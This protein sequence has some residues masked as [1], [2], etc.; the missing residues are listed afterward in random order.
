[1]TCACSLNDPLS[2]AALEELER[3]RV[4]E[5]VSGLGNPPRGFYQT[6]GGFPCD[7]SSPAYV[8][9]ILMPTPNYDA[10]S[11]DQKFA[12]QNIDVYPRWRLYGGPFL[13]KQDAD[14]WDQYLFFYAFNTGQTWISHGTVCIVPS[15]V[16]AW[17]PNAET[18]W[19]WVSETKKPDLAQKVWNKNTGRYEINWV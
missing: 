2:K 5:W 13:V 11:F 4:L 6:D 18:N 10:L 9:G 16:L 15:S 1:V 12:L 17:P 19:D 3:K 8:R 7:F 14:S